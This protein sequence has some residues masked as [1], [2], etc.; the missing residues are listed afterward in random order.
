[1]ETPGSSEISLLLK[2]CGEGD[3]EAEK[4]LFERVYRDLKR[5]ARALFRTESL[6]TSIQ[7]TLLVHEAFLRMPR[8]GEIDWKGRQ[9]FFAIAARAMRR[10]LVDHARARHALKRPPPQDRLELQP[11]MAINPANPGT[12]IAIDEALSRLASID[13]RAAQVIEM[14]FFAGMKTTEIAQLLSVSEKTV[15]RDWEAG[16][17]YL[18]SELRASGQA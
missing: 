11:N 4:Q 17:L 9:H 10:A 2:R 14:R 15:N 6:E 12:L 13:A 16:R 3:G 18:Y 7:P 8:A 1:M 5:I